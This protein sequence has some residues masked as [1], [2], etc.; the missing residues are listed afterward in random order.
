LNDRAIIIRA[1]LGGNCGW[2][3]LFI[4]ISCHISFNYFKALIEE[5]EKGPTL[6]AEFIDQNQRR[7]LASG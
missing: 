5:V 4:E 6:A 7:R 1:W 2:P 3:Q